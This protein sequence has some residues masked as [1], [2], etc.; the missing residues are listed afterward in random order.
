MTASPL[1]VS[2]IIASTREGRLGPTVAN[3]FVKQVSARDD[4]K[5]DVLDLAGMA[6]PS[7]DFADSIAAADAVIVVVPEYNHSFP[8]ALKTAID[9][10]R[11]EWRAKP[12][13]FVTYGGISG[14]LRAAEALRLVFAE[15]DA[16]TI[17][18]TVSFA[19][20]WDRFDEA[21]DAKEAPEAEAA[22]RRLLDQLAWWATALRSGR[23]SRPFVA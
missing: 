12:V 2:V 22:A 17:R 6:I 18:H 14:G 23:E 20:A 21:G 15:L 16:V 9:S 1:Y 19:S 8:G 10:L 7:R 13:A 11:P 3:W 5:V 4:M